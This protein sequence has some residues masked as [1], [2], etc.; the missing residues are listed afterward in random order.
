MT[1]PKCNKETC[2]LVTKQDKKWKR[3]SMGLF[4]RILFFP[5]IVIWKL[6]RLLFGRAQDYHKTQHWHC[7]Y[8]GND[9]PA[10]LDEE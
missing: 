6:F 3:D 7:N 2:V 9:F 10:K 4:W 1:C 5:F 8:C